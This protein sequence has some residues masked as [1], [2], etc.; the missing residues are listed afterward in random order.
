MASMFVGELRSFCRVPDSISL[1]L[2]DGP[3]FS[4]VEEADN[5]IYFTREQFAVGLRFPVL[6]LVNQFL[7]VTMTLLC[8]FIRMF[9]GF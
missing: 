8:L 7:H 3:T 9:F 2:L 6:P 5:A 1:E 4:N